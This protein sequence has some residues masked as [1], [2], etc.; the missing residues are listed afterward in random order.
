MSADHDGCFIVA[1]GTHSLWARRVGDRD[2]KPGNV[3]PYLLC[4]GVECELP[5]VLDDM[6]SPARRAWASAIGDWLK[7]HYRIADGAQAAMSEINLAA[8]R[9]RM[10]RARSAS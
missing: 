9:A 3:V 5:A 6:A 8:N 7:G 1:L 2:G 4:E 10:A